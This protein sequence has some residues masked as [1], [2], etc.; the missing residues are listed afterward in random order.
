MSFAEFLNYF[1]WSSILLNVLL[2]FVRVI[3]Q[4]AV[5]IFGPSVAF[6]TAHMAPNLY[7]KYRAIRKQMGR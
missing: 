2:L 5:L 1:I 4:L 3:G 6:L 7:R